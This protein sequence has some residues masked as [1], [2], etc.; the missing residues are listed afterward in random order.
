MLRRLETFSDLLGRSSIVATH[1]QDLWQGLETSVSIV[2][3]KTSKL[4]GTAGQYVT[5]PA[6][7][8][9]NAPVKDIIAYVTLVEITQD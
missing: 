7:N 9:S 1:Q 4:S 6:R 8:T 5:L 3:T 2:E